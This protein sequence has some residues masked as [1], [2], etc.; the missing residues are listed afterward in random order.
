MLRIFLIV[1]ILFLI[2]LVIV[3]IIRI[4]D[5]VGVKF[6][7]V[8]RFKAFANVKRI[9]NNKNENE[10]NDDRKNQRNGKSDANILRGIGRKRLDSIIGKNE[11]MD[12]Q[13]NH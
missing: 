5:D 3:V 11:F 4:M 13:L 8:V 10:K 12:G 7:E 1:V 2:V 6:Q 9:N